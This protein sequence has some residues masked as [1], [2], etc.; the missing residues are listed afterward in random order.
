MIDAHNL[1]PQESPKEKCKKVDTSGQQTKQF[2]TKS[3]EYN[4]T[5]DTILLS[6]GKS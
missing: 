6:M 1:S 5:D 3:M 2:I 4:N